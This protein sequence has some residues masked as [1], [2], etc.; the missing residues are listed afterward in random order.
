MK[1]QILFFICFI[2]FSVLLPA[3]NSLFNVQQDYLSRHDIV[4]LDPDYNGFNGFPLG[5]GDLGGML[6]LTKEGLE[7]QINKIDLYDIPQNGRMTLRSAGQLKIDFGVPC[8]DYLYLKDFQARLSLKDALS[9]IKGSTPFDN[10]T[11]KSWVDTNSNV[12]VIDCS[13]DD[14]DSSGSGYA[15]RISLER[16]GSRDYCSWYS[17]YNKD[18]SNGLGNAKAMSLNKDI[19]VSDKFDGGLSFSLACRVIYPER[20]VEQIS[21]RQECI[22]LGQLK[23]KHFQVLLSIVT[24]NESSDPAKSAIALLDRAEK[25]GTALLEQEHLNWW[26]SFWNKSFVHLDNDYL[27]NIYYLRR[28]LMAS[29]S[30]G[31]FLSPF[32]G[33]LWVWNKDIRQW[34]TPHHWNTQQSYW[35]L[36]EQNDC[37][38]IRPY[39]NT[40]YRLMPEAEEY[41]AKR[42]VKDAILWTEAHDFSGK[43]VSADWG[44]M[45]NDFTPASQMASIFWDYYSFTDN[46]QCL[47]DTV[48]PFMKKAAEFY[49]K[50][51]KWDENKNEY[52][53]YPSQPYEHDHNSLKNCITD[54]YMIESLFKHCISA[55]RLLKKDSQKIKQ[56]THVIHH[57]WEPPIL[58]VTG[59]GDV[60]GLAYYKDGSVYPHLDEYY[61]AAKAHFYTM[62]AHTCAVFPAGIIGLDQAG[63]KYFSIAKKIALSHPDYINAITPN[64]IVAARLGLADKTV[65]RLGDMIAY[66]QHFN[67]GLF[68]NIDHWCN[69]SRYIDKVDSAKLLTQRDYIF[70]TRATYNS[71]TGNSGLWAQPFIQCGM[72]TLGVYGTAVN[73]MLMQCQENKI[74][75]F[76]ATPS[77][78]ESAFT[79][80]GK[81]RIS[82]IFV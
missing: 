5:N 37:E 30:R 53:I 82:R 33:G 58:N 47:N 65:T 1:R 9:T 63:T 39:I 35:G 15:T 51:L 52:Y 56:W 26:H 13:M 12:W 36:A 34:V 29:S 74:R 60:F 79:F 46:K 22:K 57:L 2:S 23:K 72:E 77:H 62:S 70:D 61:K 11:I 19:M 68:Y 7:M 4:Y 80:V 3:Q 78:W 55:A 64:A 27:E 71:K 25:K 48:Y 28:Y 59:M 50:Y 31:R 32:N 17:Q 54:R 49:L 40:Y 81:W 18:S 41:A 42:G 66:L 20:E 8:F 45:I 21:D 6:W 73:E 14:N 75:I 76:P 44:N 69:L 24:S 10:L 16:W 43:M 67:Q 38:L